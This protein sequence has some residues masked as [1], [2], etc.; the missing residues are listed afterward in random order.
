MLGGS[1]AG[2]WVGELAWAVERTV[3]IKV[4]RGS[5]GPD[6]SLTCLRDSYE[7]YRPLSQEKMHILI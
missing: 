2:P 3:G 6:S 5:F 4:R 1:R 7:S